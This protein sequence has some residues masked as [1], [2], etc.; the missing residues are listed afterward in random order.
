MDSE[1]VADCHQE[2]EVTE[3]DADPAFEGW[4]YITKQG[5]RW[6]VPTG[7]GYPAH[8]S[9]HNGHLTA[10]EVCISSSFGSHS[11]AMVSLTLLSRLRG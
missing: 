5:R 9:T 7:P 10:P 3:A 8:P 2:L 4:A 1:Y 11:F 6:R